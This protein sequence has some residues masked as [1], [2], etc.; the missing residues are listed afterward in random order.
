MPM[1]CGN[2]GTGSPFLDAS[3]VYGSDL[4]TANNL[5]SFAGGKLKIES[6]GLLPTSDQR[7]PRLC[8]R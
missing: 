3:V 7:R 5:R 6:N 4:E 2:T 1:A 8:R